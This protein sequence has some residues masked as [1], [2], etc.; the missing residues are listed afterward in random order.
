MVKSDGNTTAQMMV[1]LIERNMHSSVIYLKS[2]LVLCLS[3]DCEW[4]P[5]KNNASKESNE[6]HPVPLTVGMV[7]GV[8]CLLIVIVIS[9]IAVIWIA[10]KR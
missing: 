5:M 4:E 7:V 6:S 9:I 8:P 2:G 10:H 1:D 3:A